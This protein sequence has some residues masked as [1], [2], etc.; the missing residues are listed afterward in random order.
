[1]EF[2]KPVDIKSIMIELTAMDS[3]PSN[4]IAD[5]DP[6]TTRSSNPRRPEEVALDVV[7]SDRDGRT[8]TDRLPSILL[9]GFRSYFPLEKRLEAVVGLTLVF[10]G[11]SMVEVS[12]IE[13]L[14]TVP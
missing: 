10:P 3:R 12:E 4:R 1:M 14:G 11:P 6:A 7:Y 5:V 13:V 9:S 2:R 8:R